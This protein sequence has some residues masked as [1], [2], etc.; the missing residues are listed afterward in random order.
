MIHVGTLPV[1]SF[2][3]NAFGLHDM[4]G[5]VWEWIQDCWHDHY[6]YAPD[7]GSAWQDENGGDCGR[8]VVRGGSWEF[9]PQYLRSAFRDGYIIDEAIDYLGFRIARVF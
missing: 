9:S 5:N 8:R 6:G 3:P 2:A 4:H 7:D 1:G